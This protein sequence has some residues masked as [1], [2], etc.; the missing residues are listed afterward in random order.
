[1]PPRW[2]PAS[3]E[4]V[5]A[6]ETVRRGLAD[7]GAARDPV[8]H[9]LGPRVAVRH[10]PGKAPPLLEGGQVGEPA[11]KLQHSLPAARDAVFLQPDALAAR[12]LRQFVARGSQ[13]LAALRDDRD[14]IAR[15]GLAD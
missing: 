14:V 6:R 5:V 8:G 4:A 12:H 3:T 15:H 11:V 1:M 10:G 13:K 2:P 7:A 9:V